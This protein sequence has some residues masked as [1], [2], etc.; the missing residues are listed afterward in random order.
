[1]CDVSSTHR[2]RNVAPTVLWYDFAM[3]LEWPF[4]TAD[5]LA[6]AYDPASPAQSAPRRLRARGFISDGILHAPHHGGRL[7]GKTVVYCALNFNAVEAARDGEHDKA[8]QLAACAAEI[9][10]RPDV[11]A[12][13]LS[14]DE[15]DHPNNLTPKERK[16]ALWMVK[17]MRRARKQSAA[18]GDPLV[19][20]VTWVGAHSVR[21]ATANSERFDLP[22]ETLHAHDLDRAGAAVAVYVTVL[23]TGWSAFTVRPALVIDEKGT[24]EPR[25]YDP[26]VMLNELRARIAIGD[27]VENDDPGR[28][29][30]RVVAPLRIER[31]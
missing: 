22:R 13:A 16:T 7:R 21:L 27:I 4:V 2:Y 26:F 25:R 10:A 29:P 20:Y 15:T 28:E 6:A 1:M 30:V 12:L 23:K 3:I 24:G 9:E 14:L 11:H 8:R 31:D 5:E 19:G 17:T 18:D